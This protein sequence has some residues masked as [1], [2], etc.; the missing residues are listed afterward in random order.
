M[1]LLNEHHIKAG[2]AMAAASAMLGRIH[3]RVSGINL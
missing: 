1:R 3:A 2:R